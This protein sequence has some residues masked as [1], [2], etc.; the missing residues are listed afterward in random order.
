MKT[1]LIKSIIIMGILTAIL[2]LFGC[3]RPTE[4]L[5]HISM[6][7][8]HMNSA[9]CYGF[10]VYKSE[11]AYMFSAWCTT[12]SQIIDFENVKITD[13]EFENFKTFDEKYNFYLNER[14]RKN[15]QDTA[16][17]ATTRTFKVSYGLDSFTL[18]TDNEC[19]EE[20]YDYFISLA[21]KY[22]TIQEE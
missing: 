19:Y 13:E 21:K 22:A 14:E 16:L 10:S 15:N 12:D 7:Q 1:T 5:S 9:D 18:K 4:E 2:S 17:D 6:T 3:S 8:N 20:V 11:D